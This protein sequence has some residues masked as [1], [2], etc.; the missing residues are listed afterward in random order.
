M[1]RD[2]DTKGHEYVTIWE[3]LTLSCWQPCWYL[4]QAGCD[5]RLDGTQAEVENAVSA[6]VCAGK[7]NLGCA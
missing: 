2:A 1:A 5:L 7:Y 6:G 3:T 4:M